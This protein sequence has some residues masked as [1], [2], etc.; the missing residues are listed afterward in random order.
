MVRRYKEIIAPYI[1]AGGAN[2]L[3]SEKH[4]TKGLLMQNKLFQDK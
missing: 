1:F 3:S 2:T 4:T